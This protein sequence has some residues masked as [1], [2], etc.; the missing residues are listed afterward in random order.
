M[1]TIYA[2]YTILA[3]GA[4]NIAANFAVI[5]LIFTRYGKKLAENPRVTAILWITWVSISLAAPIFVPV[6]YQMELALEI[7][8][9]F[10]LV[11][12]PLGMTMYLAMAWNRRRTRDG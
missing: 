7:L 1:A 3:M 12:F 11:S 4:I 8:K 9:S 10:P 2:E 6:E 5:F